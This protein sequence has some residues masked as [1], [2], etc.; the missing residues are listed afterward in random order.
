[1][2]YQNKNEFEKCNLFGLG[3]PN[4]AFS[5]FFIGN[6]YLNPLTEQGDLPSFLQT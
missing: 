5:Q 1:M 6:S 2:K 4:A 3:A